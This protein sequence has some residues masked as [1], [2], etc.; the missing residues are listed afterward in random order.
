MVMPFTEL[1]KCLE[2]TGLCCDGGVR[3]NLNSRLAIQVMVVLQDMRNANLLLRYWSPQDTLQI[4]QE[5]NG[6]YMSS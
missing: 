4:H 2:G 1:W 5:K 6:S 3:D